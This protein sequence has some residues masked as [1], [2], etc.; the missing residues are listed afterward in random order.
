MRV[1]YVDEEEKQE[2]RLFYVK[3]D[4]IHVPYAELRATQSIEART[5]KELIDKILQVYYFN[6]K[7]RDN[8]ELWSKP[9]G[10]MGRERLD[11]KSVIPKEY[12]DVWV[13]GVVNNKNQ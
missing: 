9:S 10:S 5:T 2:S 4:N 1:F 12:E 11:T 6:E 8:L 7:L 3:L 13:R